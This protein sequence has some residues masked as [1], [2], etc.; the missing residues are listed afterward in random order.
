MNDTQKTVRVLILEN[1]PADTKLI[2]EELKNSGIAVSLFY[3][4]TRKEFLGIL[5]KAPPD[6]ILSDY[7]LPAYSGLTAMADAKK[8]CPDLPFIFV[9]REIHEQSVIDTLKAGATDYVFIEHL[10]RLILSVHRALREVEERVALDSAHLEIKRSEEYFRSLIENSGDIITVLDRDGVIR[11]AS[12][13]ITKILGYSLKE[14]VGKNILEF[15]HSE[16]MD[17]ARFV[18]TNNDE[19]KELTLELR[20]HHKNGSWKGLEAVGRTVIDDS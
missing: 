19:K 20:F 18:F 11:Y 4:K 12:P 8:I 16:D 5:Q 10:S 7:A 1:D 17:N 9:S 3:A 15:V 13:S 14:F 2:E 6:L